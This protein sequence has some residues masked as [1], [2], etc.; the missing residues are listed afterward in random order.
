MAET[1][2]KNY[3]VVPRDIASDYR[4]GRINRA[5]LNAYLWMRIN[6]NPYGIAYMSLETVAE[7]VFGSSKKK[8]YANKVL[9]SLKAK[10]LIFYEQRSGRRG[11]FEVHFDNWLTPGGGIKT[12]KPLFESARVRRK[13]V[14]LTNPQ[15]ELYSENALQFQRSESEKTGSD[16]ED[17]SQKGE[18][19]FRSADNDT[20]TENDNETNRQFSYG[21][22]NLSLKEF[23]PIS[24]EE[25][26]CLAFAKELGEENMGFMIGSLKKHG[27]QVIEGAFLKVKKAIEKGEADNPRRL[28]NYH[29][30]HWT[31]E[32]LY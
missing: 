7:D 29:V 21:K 26:I 4:N 32:F 12:L 31:E 20:D 25:Q 15:S 3:V 6:A 2:L 10:S 30:Q 13:K 22:R 28:F 9:L 5:E 23:V 19:A 8:N 27:I 24:Y 1:E 18:D 16:T 17:S 11:T 14:I